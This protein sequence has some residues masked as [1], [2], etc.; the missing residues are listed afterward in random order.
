MSMQVRIQL[1]IMMFLEFFVWGA[2]Y[3]TMGTYLNEIGFQGGDIGSAYSTTA[4]AAIIS[5][6]FIGMVAARFFNAER[7]L[8]VMHLLGEVLLYLA[9]TVTEP[10][11]FFWVLLGY[12]VCYM[13]TIA[14]VNA[15]AFYQMKDTEKEFPG[16]RVLGTI[17]WIVAGIAITIL[18]GM[19]LVDINFEATAYPMKIAAGISILLGLYS[20]MLPQT[21]PK[22]TP[23]KRRRAKSKT[24][25]RSPR[26]PSEARRAARSWTNPSSTTRKPRPS[27]PRATARACAGS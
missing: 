2:W 6:F 17:G 14:L 19:E 10:G 26:T 11:L 12:A 25:S 8:G 27:Q 18:D 16:I 5:P 15:I 4:W 20:F 1:S 22:A 9:S 23:C 24:A 3:V 13:P 21:P 7:V